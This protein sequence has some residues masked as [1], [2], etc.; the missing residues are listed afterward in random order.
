LYT[1]TVYSFIN[2]GLLV[3]EKLSLQD[4]TLSIKTSHYQSK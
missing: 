1:T 3:K 4:I 2:I